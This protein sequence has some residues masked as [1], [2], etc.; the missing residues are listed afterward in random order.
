MIVSFRDNWLR[1]FFVED[2]RSKKIPSGLESR[3]FRKIQMIDDATTDQDYGFR[4]AT[5]SRSYAGIWKACVRSVSINNGDSSSS[6]MAAE[7]KRQASIW[8]TIVICEAGHV[9]D[10]AQAG[11]RW[12]NSA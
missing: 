1:D 5:I 2:I 3:L 10:K 6:G 12:R 8:T 7:A 4:P 11:E 9:D